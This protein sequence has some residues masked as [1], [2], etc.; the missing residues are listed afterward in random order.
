MGGLWEGVA[1]GEMD[2]SLP[3]PTTQPPPVPLGLA[4]GDNHCCRHRKADFH[5]LHRA[6]STKAAREPPPHASAARGGFISLSQEAKS[7]S[8]PRAGSLR[9]VRKQQQG[10]GLV[11]HAVNAAAQPPEPGYDLEMRDP[12]R[13]DPFVEIERTKIFTIRKRLKDN[14]LLEVSL[15]CLT[16]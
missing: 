10:T 2:T 6:G 7:T 4:G 8:S 9:G 3:L 15:P 1:L 13:L 5:P 11:R 16:L 14:V 12:L